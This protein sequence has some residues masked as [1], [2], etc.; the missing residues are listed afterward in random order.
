MHT[1]CSTDI[2]ILEGYAI[3]KVQWEP[4]PYTLKIV[5]KKQRLE[6]HKKVFK[7][8]DALKDSSDTLPILGYHCNKRK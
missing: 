8:K 5:E 1:I 4:C 3:F 7:N 2:S 6:N